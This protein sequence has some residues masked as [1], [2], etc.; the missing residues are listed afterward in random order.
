[1]LPLEPAPTAK[2]IN[3][4]IA[5]HTLPL[6]VNFSQVP[7][8]GLLFGDCTSLN[9]LRQDSQSAN[10]GLA[11]IKIQLLAFID[12]QK[13]GC[14]RLNVILSHS[15][16]FSIIFHHVRA[17]LSVSSLHVAFLT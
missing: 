11:A 3:D 12:P 5:V 7:C 8:L 2:T 13:V 16:S 9:L 4:W 17:V 15:C 14:F 10:L 6:V 1:M